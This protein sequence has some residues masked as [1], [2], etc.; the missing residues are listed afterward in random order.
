MT[1][2]TLDPFTLAASVSC[3]LIPLDRNPC[4][5]PIGVEEVLLRIVG[6]CMG[7]VLKVDIQLAAGTLQTATGLQ[8]GV[9]AAIQSM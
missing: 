1:T 3:Q 7:W 9:E 2:E 4:V 6:K 5:R 8:S